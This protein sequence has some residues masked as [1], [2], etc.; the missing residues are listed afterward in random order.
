MARKMAELAM[1]EPAI[2]PVVVPQELIAQLARWDIP[3]RVA[4][5]GLTVVGR[6]PVFSQ[7]DLLGICAEQL[8]MRVARFS[9][10]RR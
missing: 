1:V 3:I 9:R 5:N 7:G 8:E 6:E 4:P 10:A 2:S